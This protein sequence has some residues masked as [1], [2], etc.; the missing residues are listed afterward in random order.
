MPVKALLFS[1]FY[2]FYTFLSLL[3]NVTGQKLCN[4]LKIIFFWLKIMLLVKNGPHL[5][6]S[7][8]HQHTN[9]TLFLKIN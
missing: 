7:K 8:S 3:F 9:E 2:A 6:D 4:H 1:C 5:S